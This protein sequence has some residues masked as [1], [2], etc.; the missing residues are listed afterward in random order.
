[1]ASAEALFSR[2]TSNSAKQK[3]N[4]EQE[5]DLEVTQQPN[6]PTPSQ[7][8]NQSAPTTYVSNLITV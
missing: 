2:G 7:T 5:I 4:K 8:T 3:E 1:M 6:E